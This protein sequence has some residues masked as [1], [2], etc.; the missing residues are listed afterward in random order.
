MSAHIEF[1]C[2]ECGTAGTG[3]W[4]RFSM[5][6]EK[7]N[8]WKSFGGAHL[9]GWDCLIEHIKGLASKDRVAR[10]FDDKPKEQPPRPESEASA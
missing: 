6:A 10:L 4:A 1:R 7:P 2:D 9:C 8:G 5:G 3:K